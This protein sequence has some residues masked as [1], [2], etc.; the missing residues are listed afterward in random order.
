MCDRPA[1]LLLLLL[2]DVSKR[3]S[4][5]SPVMAHASHQIH[6][7]MLAFPAGCI[8]LCCLRTMFWVA[9]SAAWAASPFACLSPCPLP[10]IWGALYT[11]ARLVHARPQTSYPHTPH[12]TAGRDTLYCHVPPV[13]YCQV[14]E[15][16]SFLA[17]EDE[18][19]EGEEV[20]TSV[21]LRPLTQVRGL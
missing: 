21:N 5:A 20:P 18:E 10:Y 13:L 4:P 7:H 19:D 15:P 11:G 8:T 16:F 6:P 1:L 14:S 9:N 17:G 3:L 2:P 12:T